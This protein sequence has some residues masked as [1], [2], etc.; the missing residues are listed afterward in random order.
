MQIS[1]GENLA[2]EIANIIEEY[3]GERVDDVSVESVIEEPHL[4]FSM[5]FIAY[6][7]YV[8]KLNYDRG[9]FGCCI[10]MSGMDI[11]L[12]NSQKWYDEADMNIFCQELEKEIE[13]RIPDKFLEA[14]G[15]KKQ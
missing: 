2:L 9:R 4:E 14:K 15:W 1:K 11:G 13:L 7:Y 8:I 3:F 5:D 12:D 10:A 6:N